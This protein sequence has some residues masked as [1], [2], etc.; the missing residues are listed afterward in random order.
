MMFECMSIVKMKRFGL[1][2]TSKLVE[3][4]ADS[5]VGEYVGQTQ[6]KVKDLLKEAE[7]GVLF[8]DEAHRLAPGSGASAFK[9]EALGVLMKALEP[10]GPY[11]NKILIIFAGYEDKL[12]IL[13]E[14]DQGLA[15]R[16]KCRVLFED[17][18]PN[19]AIELFTIALSK[20]K[21]S[22][23]NSHLA[24]PSIANGRKSCEHYIAELFR[25]LY[26]H[27]NWSNIADVNYIV[28]QLVEVAA[29]RVQKHVFDGMS[30][31]SVPDPT[32]FEHAF[33][34]WK[35]DFNIDDVMKVSQK[36]RENRKRKRFTGNVDMSIQSKNSEETYRFANDIKSKQPRYEPV[37]PETGDEEVE[38]ADEIE[39]DPVDDNNI[40]S[41]NGN[42]SGPDNAKV[43]LNKLIAVMG[44]QIVHDGM[45][46]SN[47][48]GLE[49]LVSG[50]ASNQ[51]AQQA[52][53]VTV[54]KNINSLDLNKMISDKLAN[55]REKM[56]Y[57]S[58]ELSNEIMSDLRKSKKYCYLLTI[59][60]GKEAQ[61]LLKEKEKKMKERFMSLC[62]AGFS[63]VKDGRGYRCCGGSHYVD[64]SAFDI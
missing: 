27:E 46:P 16:F 30:S 36:M 29:A 21:Y 6:Q 43:M 9:E 23:D 14:S 28:E 5:I 56:G 12:D 49:A 38:D 7:G 2:P 35:Q 22:F 54:D 31:A 15:R 1:L 53:N 8:I 3:R 52:L 34:D 59:N 47:A 57:K 41:N 58:E 50:I 48:I 62:P 13:L 63:W 25:Y 44:V 39:E 4:N 24:D 32:A 61:R 51:G 19:R 37:E 42:G 18:L 60:K 17:I 11:Y 64:A 26:G 55:L 45:D 33:S 10:N 20:Q 40:N